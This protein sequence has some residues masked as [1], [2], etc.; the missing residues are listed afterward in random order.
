MNPLITNGDAVGRPARRQVA[1]GAAWTVPVLMV[2]AAA[3]SVAASSS[4]PALAFKVTGW[5]DKCPGASD[6]P[7]GWPKHGNRVVLTVL[8]ISGSVTVD[9]VVL[10]N[11][12]SAT[13]LTDPVQ[14]TSS[15]DWEFVVDADSSPS[16][17]TVLGSVDGK[18]FTCAVKAFPH[19][20]VRPR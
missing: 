12:K 15:W 14:V 5:A 3:P 9:S 20:E 16:T 11:G 6:V 7:G 18:P 17:L 2:A 4:P 13:V 8:P 19:C 10:G 1:K